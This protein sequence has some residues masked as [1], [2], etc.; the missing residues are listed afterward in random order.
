MARTIFQNAN[1]LDGVSAA[2]P[3]ATVTVNGRTIESVSF[4]PPPKATP[5]DRVVDL[6]GRTLMPG[7]VICHYHSAY[8]GVGGGARLP[9]GMDTPIGMQALRGAYNMKLTLDSGFTGAV[10]AGSANGI[11]VALK[12]GM[13]AGLIVGP[14]LVASGRDVSTTGHSLD[15]MMPHFWKSSYDGH[16]SRADGADE[17]RRAV[18]MEVNNGAEIVKLFV[19]GGHG[20]GTPAEQ[21]EMTAEELAAAIDA[22]HGHGARARGHIANG[23]AIKLALRLGMDIIDHG[24]GLDDEG[25]D[26]LLQKDVALAPS[27]LFPQV[28]A[29]RFGGERAKRIRIS[30]ERDNETFRKANQAGVRL[31]VGDDYGT[32]ALE[33]GRYAEEL[34]HYVSQVGI[35]ALD[36]IRWATRN[37]AELLGLGDQIG[38]IAPGK[39]ADLLVVDGDP[40]RDI[41]VL[42]DRANLH[43]I[44]KDGVFHKD[45][46]EAAQGPEV[47][48]SVAA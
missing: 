15:G 30:S 19:T 31:V 26:L 46:L 5:E 37:G 29:E 23:E 42:K 25:I 16:F 47:G 24:D 8:F 38:T 48:V 6:A 13:E 45:A 10:S 32:E 21:M 18:R 14:R 2:R 11:D 43:A 33:H 22:A 3:G 17:M 35:P 40:S 28:I 1:L 44:V 27:L 36:V 12:Q 7:M 34:E 39:L 20:V 41:T 9:V 4:G